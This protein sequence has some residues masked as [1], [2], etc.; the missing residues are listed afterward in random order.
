[1]GPPA[2]LVSTG[3]ALT[4]RMSY[5]ASTAV[6]DVTFAVAATNAEGL[7]VLVLGSSDDAVWAIAAG[8]GHVELRMSQ[9]LLAPGTYT[10]KSTVTAESSILDADDAGVPLTI[11]P[12]TL[13]VGGVYRQPCEWSLTSY[14]ESGDLHA[15]PGAV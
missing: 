14:S 8:S 13:A 7:P 4:V 12:G 3:D 5:V 6:S 10:L 9:C 15:W 1:M 2:P 11:R